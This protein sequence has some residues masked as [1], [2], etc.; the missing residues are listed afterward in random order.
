MGYHL[1]D[2]EGKKIIRSHDVIFNEK[3]MHKTPIK[4]VEMCRV[5]FQDVNPPTHH[6]RTQVSYALNVDQMLQPSTPI[7]SQQRTNVSSS[8]GGHDELKM[9]EI[10]YG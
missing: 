7:G 2:R 3:K 8:I 10:P 9:A 1:R 6:G 4:H 5:I